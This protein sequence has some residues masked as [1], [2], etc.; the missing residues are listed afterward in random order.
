MINH[1]IKP[2]IESVLNE[3]LKID[4]WINQNGWAGW[5]PYDIKSHNFFVKI[6]SLPNGI[7][8]RFANS[9]S[10]QAVDLFPLTFRKIYNIQPSINSKSLGLLLSSYC[11]LFKVTN[12]E[13]Y[14]NKA[15]DVANWLIENKT[16]QN[17]GISWGYP[18]DWHSPIFIPKNTST[19]IP[20]VTIG[21]GFYKLFE[22]T[23]DKKYINICKEICI[24]FINDLKITYNKNNAICYS[25]T[26]L[27]DY[28]VHNTNLFMGEFLTKIGKI[29]SINEFY[30]NGI[31]CG[32]FALSQ[33]Q[34][35]GYIPYWGIDQTNKYSNGV[36]HSD[37][38]HSGFEIRALFG[39]WQNTRDMRFK[40]SYERYLKWYI[41]NLFEKNMMPKFMPKSTYPIFIH[42]CT[43]SIY[44]LATLLPNHNEL[45]DLLYKSYKWTTQNMQYRRGEYIHMIKKV[46]KI[47]NKKI[48]I[49]MFRW[50]QAWMIMALSQYLVALKEVNKN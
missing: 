44:C 9:L 8:A 36:M 24:F 25:Y 21:D 26:P 23:N 49:T 40:L 10:N 14:L 1:S 35:D 13:K 39:L 48:K 34:K 15:I 50:A 5:D 17:K 7:F 42:S 32:N 41:Q 19:S 4:E 47:Y 18:F 16:N 2:P 6:S 37:H 3:A 29:L 45:N 43:E 31:K 38:Y 20:T 33:Q 22:V 12:N 28:Q 30:D 46:G 11:N 27:D